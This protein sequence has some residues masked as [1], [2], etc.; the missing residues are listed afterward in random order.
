[1]SQNPLE[2][3]HQLADTMK[4]KLEK[5]ANK[6]SQLPKTPQAGD[7]F[8][9][10]NQKT[11]GLLQWVLLYSQAEQWFIVPADDNPMTGTT[12]IAISEKALCG[13]LTLRCS[14]GIWIPE[15][16]LDLSLRVGVLENWHLYRAIDKV[17]GKIQS[18]AWQRETEAD[19]EYEEWM[20]QV[21]Q[22]R[23]T[24]KFKKPVV[25]LIQWFQNNFADWLEL[26]R[27]P[28]NLAFLPVRTKAVKRAKE[29]NLGKDY[30]VVLVL[31]IRKFDNENIEVVFWLCAEQTALPKNIKFTLFDKSSGIDREKTANGTEKYLNI[32]WSFSI[33]EEFCIAIQLDDVSFTESFML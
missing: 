11:I 29:I 17:K 2:R 20:E 3:L 13:P 7:I 15:T 18:T 33:K 9:I 27:I 1:M 12:D 21:I 24:L 8:R 4:T 14:Q 26:N 6:L 19:P 16:N 22:E 28:T 10:D 23:E 31:D 30:K 25:N 32:K 5:V